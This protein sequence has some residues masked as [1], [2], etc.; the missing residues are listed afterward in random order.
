MRYLK[1]YSKICYSAREPLLLF[2]ERTVIPL[3]NFDSDG[4]KTKIYIE[5]E[6]RYRDTDPLPIAIPKANF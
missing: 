4:K 2:E 5:Y 6:N 1:V 3:S